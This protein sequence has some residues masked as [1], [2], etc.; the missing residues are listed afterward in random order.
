MTSHRETDE[1]YRNVVLTWTH[2][3]KK[4]TRLVACKDGLQWI[5]QYRAGPNRWRNQHFCCTRAA[6]ERLLPGMADEIRATLPET[7]G[8]LP[9]IPS[10]Q[11]TS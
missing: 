1:D 8:A 7:F 10:T 9:S 4:A 3:E 6:L 11:G 5:V 2:S